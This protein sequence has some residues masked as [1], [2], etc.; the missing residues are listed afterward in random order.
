MMEEALWRERAQVTEG[1]GDEEN[2]NH[3]LL[4][5]LISRDGVTGT[6]YKEDAPCP[7]LDRQ[8]RPPGTLRRPPLS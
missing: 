5:T 4:S 6:G 8:R 3:L 7:A 2:K 1:K